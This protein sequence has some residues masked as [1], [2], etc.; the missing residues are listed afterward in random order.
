[1]RRWRVLVVDDELH[2][3]HILRLHLEAAA[4]E[5]IEAAT[6]TAALNQVAAA[7]PDVIILDLGLPD[8]SGLT[9][10]EALQRA[11]AFCTIPVIV[12]TALGDDDTQCPGM[13]A[14]ITKPFSARD[15]VTLVLHLVGEGAA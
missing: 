1:M 8:M 6:G 7:C 15:V 4:V 2:I 11:P 12:L 3:R 10:C 14:M 9:V 5:V 13:V